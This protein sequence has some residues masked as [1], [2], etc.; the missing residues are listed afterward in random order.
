[1]NRVKDRIFENFFEGHLRGQVK[2]NIIC[3]SV[4]NALGEEYSNLVSVDYYVRGDFYRCLQVLEASYGALT[5]QEHRLMLSAFINMVPSESEIELGISWQPPT[6]VR[7]G[8]RL[9]DTRLVN[10]PLRWLSNPKYRSVYSPFEKGLSHFLEAEKKPH[11]L[12]DVVT[13][14]Y[15]SKRCQN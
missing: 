1:M 3:W 8:A 4:A 9:L 14:M 11:L 10:E 6:F 12:A 15:E 7:T 13:D 5:S 2:P